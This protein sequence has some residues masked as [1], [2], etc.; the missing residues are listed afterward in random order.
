[1]DKETA[2]QKLGRKIMKNSGEKRVMSET[3]SMS[4]YTS[5]GKKEDGEKNAI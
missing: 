4:C 3:V 2:G 1:M 5:E